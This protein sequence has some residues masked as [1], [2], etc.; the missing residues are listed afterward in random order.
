MPC[1]YAE[2]R[3]AVVFCR[4]VNRV[5]N[6]FV[7][8]C[9]SERYTRCRFFQEAQKKAAAAAPAPPPVEEERAALPAIIERLRRER[10]ERPETPTPPTTPPQQPPSPGPTAT[11]PSAPEQR[12]PAETRPPT[13]LPQPSP[14]SEEKPAQQPQPSP[15]QPAPTQPSPPPAPSRET[16]WSREESE[17]LV[18]PAYMAAII[19]RAPLALRRTFNVSDL[20][21]LAKRLEL[22]ING[23]RNG[24]YLVD[25]RSSSGRIYLKYCDGS[26]V[27]SA[28][29]SEVL[30]PEKAREIVKGTL[31]VTVYGPLKE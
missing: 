19:L 24:C 27:A 15:P 8:P 1:P 26:L 10:V 13:P 11:A 18:D 2:R 7:M 31:R 17:K 21:D 25:V 30:E 12:S 14:P 5:V 22:N 4:A 28:T 23:W 9:L 20:D 16:R 3:G 6:P 29:E